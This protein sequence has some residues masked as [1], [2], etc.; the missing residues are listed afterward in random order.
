MI[1]NRKKP[2]H[3]LGKGISFV[4]AVL[5]T[6]VLLSCP[7]P[8]DNKLSL[9]VEDE[10][11]PLIT[12]IS[13]DPGTKNYYISTIN[14]SGIVKDYTD[15]GGGTEGS[16]KFLSY[17]EQYNKKIQ[18]DIDFADDGSFSFSFSTLTPEQL[19]GNQYIMITATDWNVNVSQVIVTLYDKT[20]G[21]RITVFDHGPADFNMYSS[22]LDDDMT[23]EGIVELPTFYL[24]YDLEPES[25][26]NIPDED[27]IYNNLDGT[28]SFDLNPVT[29]GVSGELRFVLKAF[30][31]KDSSTVFILTDDPVAPTLDTGTVA[32]DNTYM[33]LE[34][35]EGIYQTGGTAPSI[36]D[37]T[38]TFY[39]NG[40]TASDAVKAGFTVPP[41][42]G[43][44]SIR[45]NIAITDVPDGKEKIR[46]TASNLTDRVGNPVSAA[47]NRVEDWLHDKTS[48]TV[49]QVRSE[50]GDKNK[51]FSTGALDIIVEF[52]EVVNITPPLTLDLNTGA[53]ATYSGSGG[54]S[55]LTFTYDVQ[56]G[57]NATVLNYT[58]TDAL[59]GTVTD[60]EGNTANLDLPLLDSAFALNASNVEI[61]TDKPDPPTV[62]IDDGGNGISK[63]ESE[64]GVPFTV[65]GEAG[66]WYEI[67]TDY[68]SVI[69][70]STTGYLPASGF[71][72]EVTIVTGTVK[73]SVTQR[74]PAG[75]LS[76]PGED[77]ANADLTAPNPPDVSGTT[78]TNN[79]RPTWTWDSD[80]VNPGNRTFRYQLDGGSWSGETTDKSF[81][82]DPL[83][84]LG[85]GNHT[86]EVKEK[87]N[88]GNWSDSGS[89][90]IRVDTE[91]PNPPDVSGTTPTNNDRPTWTWDSTDP[92]DGDG[93][94]QY[95]LDE[96]GWSSAT[97][98]TD[99]TPTP[100]DPALSQGD[101]ILDVQER[102]KALNWSDSGSFTITVDWTGPSA[103]VVD[104]PRYTSDPRPTWTWNSTDPGDGD[105]W[106][107]YRL[108]GGGWSS[109]TTDTD[110]APTPSDPALSQGDHILYVQERDKA[111]N[112][113]A[114]G[115]Y[116]I[117]VD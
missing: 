32:W 102:D 80:H 39:R 76:D 29:K 27:I 45:L 49:V 84:P 106:F 68:C 85:D 117:T 116:T 55:T 101:H 15:P 42:P 22:A 79:D 113:S 60:E 62:D 115:S 103:P 73:V 66:A 6:L 7:N 108:D 5:V 23:Y 98:D 92:G 94:F 24:R 40:G 44:E 37:F 57:E 83:S 70:G 33:D 13:P 52:S 14:I 21:P 1:L 35:S 16:V 111:L 65:T 74:D 31:G 54:S 19:S 82:P 30:D 90:T 67:S 20:N 36:D 89:F 58:A 61:D 100:S 104:G 112:W 4:L 53:T 8:I 81:Q 86:L 28:F 12:I 64:A 50:A 3:N 17:D 109:A 10:T 48:P 43:A 47:Q 91:K 95:W 78:P 46:I 26:D 11:P 63:E 18:G 9:Q 51:A 72:L 56:L 25:G 71:K 34:F 59:L 105:G 87:N 38:L 69:S 41:A 77:T 97:T 88:V 2:F 110:F 99:F 114:S 93:W 107:Q 96:G 75:N